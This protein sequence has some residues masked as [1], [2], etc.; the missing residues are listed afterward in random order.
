MIS[1]ASLSDDEKRSR[2]I[3]KARETFPSLCVSAVSSLIISRKSKVD[4]FYSSTENG[5]GNNRF[6][7]SIRTKVY[8]S[9]GLL[10]NFSTFRK[11]CLKDDGDEDKE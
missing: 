7:L 5:M 4:E 3:P 11:S 2:L 6:R 9:V 1:S 10:S 8:T